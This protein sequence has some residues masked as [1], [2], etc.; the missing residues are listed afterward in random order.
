M[1]A[2][3]VSVGAIARYERGDS[4][5]TA[6]VIARYKAEFGINPDWLVTGEGEMYVDPL[7]APGNTKLRTIDQ[8]VFK[9][10]GRLVTQVHTEEGVRLP[11]DAL[12]DQQSSAYNT[13][14]E[15]AEDPSDTNELMSLLPWLEAR[16]RKSLRAA[17]AEPGT[18][19]H[20]A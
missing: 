2:L 16:I 8:T 13:L 18:G 4:E 9:Q 12:L 3:G 19:K 6:A 10:V 7:K 17:T 5:P 15:R 11:P 20:Q 1:E 14:I